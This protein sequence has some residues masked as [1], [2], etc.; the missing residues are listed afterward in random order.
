MDENTKKSVSRSTRS[1]REQ[2]KDLST[3]KSKTNK[4]TESTPK[5][6]VTESNKE[7][8]QKSSKKIDSE[9]AQRKKSADIKS[10]KPRKDKSEKASRK[11]SAPKDDDEK[12]SERKKSSRDNAQK[13]E[14]ENSVEKKPRKTKSTREDAS[15]DDR[16]KKSSKDN[17]LKVERG[18]SA[19]K[20]SKK[21]KSRKDVSK[22]DRENKSER[23]KSKRENSVRADKEDKSERKKSKRENS[24]R[25]EK[26][27]KSEK[28]SR[29]SKST[30]EAENDKKSVD[31]KSKSKREV[32]ESLDKRSRGSKPPKS[33]VKDLTQEDKG[34]AYKSPRKSSRTNENNVN[35]RGD[36][37]ERQSVD[38]KSKNSNSPQL[39]LEKKAGASKR[40]DLSEER[41]ISRKSTESVVRVSEPE[42]KNADGD[43]PST[44]GNYPFTDNFDVGWLNNVNVS[45]NFKGKFDAENL[46][47]DIKAQIT[48]NIDYQDYNN[49][50]KYC[51]GIN[52]QNLELGRG[53]NSKLFD[54]LNSGYR[55]S[56]TKF[57]YLN[58]LEEE[59]SFIDFWPFEEKPDNVMIIE[60][61]RVLKNQ[62]GISKVHCNDILEFIRENANKTSR[63]FNNDNDGP[64]VWTL[65]NL[66]YFSQFLDLID[67]FSFID[68]PMQTINEKSKEL[69]DHFD[70]L[71]NGFLDMNDAVIFFQQMAN[72]SKYEKLHSIIRYVNFDDEMVS[73][74]NLRVI[75]MG[76]IKFKLIQAYAATPQI[77][78]EGLV[79]KDKM[80]TYREQKKY[81]ME[82]E[83]DRLEKIGVI[84]TNDIYD[85]LN[86][87][88]DQLLS[89]DDQ[90]IWLENYNPE[91]TSQILG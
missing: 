4:V 77:F 48:S 47:K 91:V 35:F 38:K 61:I 85:L 42:I 25:A 36:T 63:L 70:L 12:K 74:E 40:S 10:E 82:C 65:N 20:K 9:D 90:E 32:S 29:K 69:F 73:Y 6:K 57:D 33:S 19:E 67:S 44:E 52:N 87:E 8:K 15:K 49:V 53:L 11:V 51:N 5:S 72:G 56:P 89:L 7:K 81:K 46:I 41:V 3:E 39:D 62:L 88:Y 16:E 26:E 1:K 30:R 78:L 37:P 22:D 66:M 27:D 71:R 31:K 76:M 84:T 45:A 18:D 80:K 24:V 17:T 68:E 60:P 55:K 13:I 58:I 14:K 43:L 75:F 79:E 64:S 34:S 23:K 86:K 50:L 28:K 2:E 83:L 59:F 54:S 21:S